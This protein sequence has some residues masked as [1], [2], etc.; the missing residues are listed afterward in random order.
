MLDEEL[1]TV[2]TA[3]HSNSQKRKR[4]KKKRGTADD[5]SLLLF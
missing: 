4:S 5:G 2:S 1:S 3:I